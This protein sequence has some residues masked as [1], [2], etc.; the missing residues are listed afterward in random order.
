MSQ[1]FINIYSTSLQVIVTEQPVIYDAIRN[2]LGSIGFIPFTSSICI[3]QP[4]YYYVATMVHHIEVCQFSI[5]LN[6]VLIDTPF[7][8]PTAATLLY[9]NTIIY[10]SAADIIMPCSLAPGGLAAMLETVNH[11]SY[12][13]SITL[14]NPAGSA[15]ND[16]T[17]AMTV[18]LLA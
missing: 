2:K 8:S 12:L 17:A 3:W 9:Y 10:V 14:N 5:F 18:F 7:S 6:G 13:P 11:S 1:T 4:G 16:I 15:P